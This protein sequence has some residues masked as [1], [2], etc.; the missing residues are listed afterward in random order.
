M[1]KI[2]AL[3]EL[4]IKEIRVK[5]DLASGSGSASGSSSGSSSGSGSVAGIYM[6]KHEGCNSY[7]WK[8]AKLVLVVSNIKDASYFSRS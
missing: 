2:T 1:G 8:M 3:K 7:N 5:R 4:R 6:K